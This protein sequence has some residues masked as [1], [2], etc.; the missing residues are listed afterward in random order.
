MP[1]GVKHGIKT[2][3][4]FGMGDLLGLALSGAAG[5]VAALV[6]DFQAQGEASALYT[7]NKWVV[8]VGSVLGFTD[9]PLW[10][11]VLGLTAAGA[12]SIFYFQPITRQGAFAQGFGLL[13]VLMTMTPP[14]LAGGLSAYTDSLA[15]L[16]APV[17][18]REASLQPRLINASYTPGDA[19][20][21]RVQNTTTQAA[22]Y[23]L[24]LRITFPD[25]IPDDVANMI[26]RGTIRGRLHNEDMGSTWNLFRSAGG[27]V[28]REGNSLVIH[29]GVPAR[30]D[31]AR[32]WVRIE[33]A[34]YAIEEQSA[35]A[36]LSAP[37]EW[38]VE[39]QTSNVPLPIQRL[40]K[41]YWF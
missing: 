8:E 11:V 33:A 16:E 36:D 17:D 6:T 32:L 25:G 13:A 41:S 18:A 12:G 14:N 31:S 10:M 15:P 5:I 1:Y 19:A 3:G 27:T 23:D 34:G 21:Y 4:Q 20:L 39:M 9:I 38:T 2:P 7:I 22:K 24:H 28:R 29:A 40:G 30:S 37:L 35:I 26:R